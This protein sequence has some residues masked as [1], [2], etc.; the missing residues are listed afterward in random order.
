MSRL[1]DRWDGAALTRLFDEAGVLD[2]VRAR[3]FSGCEATVVAHGLALPH[4]HLSAVKDGHRHRLLD[5]CLGR[6]AVDSPAGR[7]A[8]L[9]VQWVREQDPTA[10]FD[11]ARPRLPLQEHPGL[12]VLRRVFRVAVRLATELGD[13]AVANQPKFFHDAALFAHSRLF[14]FLDGG[15]Q[16][17]FEALQRDLAAL[18]LADATLA[19]ASWSVRDAADAV[20]HWQPGYQVFPLSERLTAHLHSTAYAEAVA[21]GATA[22]YRL[23]ATGLAAARSLAVPAS[24]PPPAA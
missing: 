21:A 5:A 14:L 6:V 17:R 12:G 23:D 20:V 10:A 18:S 19:V 7:L 1:F 16:G 13:D 22:R 3:G 8:L 2:A 9:L 11:P 24:G 4:I 15:E